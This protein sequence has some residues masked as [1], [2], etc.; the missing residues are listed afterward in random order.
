MKLSWQKNVQEFHKH[1]HFFVSSRS[2]CSTLRKMLTNYNVSS[3]RECH[4]QTHD[5]FRTILLELSSTS[6]SSSSDSIWSETVM[7]LTYVGPSVPQ[8]DVPLP[9][10]EYIRDPLSVRAK[11]LV[12]KNNISFSIWFIWCENLVQCVHICINMFTRWH[13]T[14]ILFTSFLL[15]KSY[16]HRQSTI[17]KQK[18]TTNSDTWK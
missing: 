18:Y 4:L 16:Q 15:Y 5:V 6:A 13:P 11:S 9:W 10:S 1:H 3:L 7:S 2:Y 12:H 17:T 14:C 8:K